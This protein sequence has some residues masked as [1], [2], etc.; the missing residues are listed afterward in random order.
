ME[1]GCGWERRDG[2]R[3]KKQKEGGGGKSRVGG[4]GWSGSIRMTLVKRPRW[5]NDFSER[6]TVREDGKKAVT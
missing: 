3:G 6:K 5:C 1:E 4:G 2:H